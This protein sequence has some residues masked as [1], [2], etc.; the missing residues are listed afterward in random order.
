MWPFL[1]AV[2]F[3]AAVTSGSL[4]ALHEFN[5]RDGQSERGDK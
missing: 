2:H 3:G 4:A 5:R 1:N